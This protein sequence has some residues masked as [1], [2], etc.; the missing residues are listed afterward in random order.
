MADREW[1]SPQMSEMAI[2]A[3]RWRGGAAVNYRNGYRS[4]TSRSTDAIWSGYSFGSACGWR[5]DLGAADRALALTP[6]ERG[7]AMPFSLNML[8]WV[9]C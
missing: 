7:R 6:Q 3:S 8:G 4:V 5:C 2:S 9:K 1:P